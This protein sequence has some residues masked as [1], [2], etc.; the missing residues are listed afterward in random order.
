MPRGNRAST[1]VDIAISSATNRLT[2]Q[3][4]AGDESTENKTGVETQC[5]HASDLELL[6]GLMICWRG[7]IAHGD[8][9]NDKRRA[10]ELAASFMNLTLNFITSEPD[11]ANQYR[12]RFS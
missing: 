3:L 10:S 9:A 6:Q 1:L 12:T 2:H 8:D 4:A 7:D 5:S 11:F